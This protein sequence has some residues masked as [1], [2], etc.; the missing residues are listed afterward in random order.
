MATTNDDYAENTAPAVAFEPV[1]VSVIEDSRNEAHPSIHMI[2]PVPGVSQKRERQSSPRSAD[3]PTEQVSDDEDDE[4]DT[5]E[6]FSGLL[7][8][9][10]S[11][12]S[13]QSS[14]ARL[15]MDMLRKVSP[16]CCP[17]V[18]VFP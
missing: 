8:D 18:H 7:G 14:S 3:A 10:S 17:F 15:T 11:A 6:P 16:A 2:S 5:C 4:D 13:R 9:K 12:A 1:T